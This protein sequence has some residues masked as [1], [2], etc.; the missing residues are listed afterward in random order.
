MPRM[1]A[2]LLVPVLVL[3]F[4]LP[5]DAKTIHVR[6]GQSIQAAVDRAKPG[7]RILIA[8]GTYR[9]NGG[10][11]PA[12]SA[13]T[14]A[15]AIDKNDIKLIGVPRKGRPV[16]L[17]AKQ[18]QDAGI[19]VGKPREGDCLG[20]A[21]KR[22]HG[23][24]IRG[25]TVRDFDDFGVFLLCVDHWR[26][27]R[28][29]AIDNGEYGT[30]PAHTTIGRLDHSFASGSNDTGHY[31]GQSSRARVDHNVAKDNVSG[32]ELENSSHIRADHN[33]ATG[34]TG[35]ILSFT[36]PNLDVKS[37]SD[38]RIDHNRVAGN[39]RKNT[40]LEPEDA[41]CSVP[42]GTGI[43]MLAVDRNRVEANKVTGNRSYGIAVANYCIALGMSAED[44]AALDIE[45][46]PDGNRVTGNSVK[47][48]GK[49]PD[50]SVPSV[51]TVDLAW[52]TSGTGNCWSNNSAG[53]TFP[54]PL[55]ACP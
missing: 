48:N 44:C 23:S 4:A 28:V 30:F 18:G 38:N 9:E 19:E 21:S 26:I 54:S 1:T 2:L 11:C 10:P 43:L 55:P 36:L 16:V 22:I 49:N 46:N 14:C 53:T 41:V 15:V 29:R 50:P 8:P 42:P 7:D 39:N 3:A 27:T 6:K 33:V 34:N 52:D 31:I 32:F 51:F 13:Q 35:G 20:D 24:L 12:V 25:I 5:A 40:C 17:R 45:P 47:Q 37:N